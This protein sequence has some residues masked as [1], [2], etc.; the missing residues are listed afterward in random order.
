MKLSYLSEPELE[1]GQG[2]HICPRIGITEYDVYDIQSSPRRNSIFVGAVGTADNLEKLDNWIKK[3]SYY[4]RAEN[5]ENKLNLWIDFC[6]FN[7]ES[8][9]KSQFIYEEGIHRK[10]TTSEID[11]IIKI[12]DWNTR[13]DKAVELYYN[14]I[15][16]L[17]QNR[18]VDV[19]VC[20]LS[21]KLCDS[22]MSDEIKTI[23]K[24]EKIIDNEDKDDSLETN[25]RRAL[26]AKSMHLGRPIQIILEPTLES[27]VKGKHD[28]AT[29]AWN[30][31]TAIYYK[32]S[33]STIPWKLIR[34]NNQPSS[35]FVGISFYR[36]RDRK[37]LNTSL[38][39]LFDELGNS[40]I[41][42]GN[43]V[44]IDKNDRQ[45][46]LKADQAYTLLTQALD[47]YYNAMSNS[48]GRLVIHKTSKYNDEEIDGFKEAA[49]KMNVKTTDFITII[50]T[51]FRLFR[52]KEY[53]PYRGTHI[54]LDQKNHL[55]YTRGSVQHYQTYPG[56]YIPTPLEIR[57]IQSDESPEAICKE[58]L[59][60]TK[61]NWNN[62][63]F[64]GKYPISISCS[65]NVGQVMKYLDIN[66]DQQPQ[67]NYSYYM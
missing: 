50:D 4:I 57:I 66:K 29:K 42:R 63:Q 53:P 65:R 16:F 51:N 36:S 14:N 32:S 64:D 54:E 49:K 35:C 60:L 52:A 3:C 47:E 19:I 39:Q 67:I 58:I 62:T 33:P 8:G 5:K 45:P 48:P 27:N 11:E 15:K 46:H 26:K 34:N 55:L 24:I 41:L 10:L 18:Q 40:V 1:F 59:A 30:L 28:D 43:P 13:I 37:V 31:C 7:L 23:D 20:L 6:G 38:A 44:D 22:I 17:A 2:S 9:F 56:S 21:K 25:F 61:M 12:E